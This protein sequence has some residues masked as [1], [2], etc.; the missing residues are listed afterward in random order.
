M[1]DRILGFEFGRIYQ[2]SKF[3]INIFKNHRFGQKNSENIFLCLPSYLRR[4]SIQIYKILISMEKFALGW[5]NE[6]P[7]FIKKIP[8]NFYF[9]FGDFRGLWIGF[10]RNQSFYLSLHKIENFFQNEVYTYLLIYIVRPNIR[11]RFGDFHWISRI[12]GF[13]RISLR[14]GRNRTFRFSKNNIDAHE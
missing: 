1:I 6:L 5:S 11:L 9:R 8:T 3:L 12:L 10:S 7:Y 4:T 2:I 13:G 14:F